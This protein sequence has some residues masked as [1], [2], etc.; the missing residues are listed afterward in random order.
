MTV[1]SVFPG[2]SAR[3]SYSRPPP[4]PPHTHTLSPLPPPSPSLISLVVSVDVKLCGL[5]A[6][7]L[8]CQSSGLG[9]TPAHEL[10]LLLLLLFCFSL[11]LFFFFLPPFSFFSSSESRNM[12]SR[13]YLSRHRAFDYTKIVAHVKYST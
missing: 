8:D 7:V 6:N 9:S 4:P 5:L 2:R 13:Q 12:Q 1:S 3:T 10:L 11:C